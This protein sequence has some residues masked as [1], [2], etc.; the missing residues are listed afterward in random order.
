M[1]RLMIGAITRMTLA[2][3]LLYL[4]LSSHNSEILVAA[5]VN[6]TPEWIELHPKG[7]MHTSGKRSELYVEMLNLQEGSVSRPFAFEDGSKV[8]LD[9]VLL[10]QSGEKIRLESNVVG[11]GVKAFLRLSTPELE[12]KHHDYSFRTISLRSDTTLKVGR[13]VWI[14]YDP[15]S[16]KDGTKIPE[17]F[18]KD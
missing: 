12:W 6:L 16:T 7:S 17:T 5:S 13:I 11:F 9:G 10:S 1:K 8:S 14:S 2:G 18:L 4:L 15:E 3:G